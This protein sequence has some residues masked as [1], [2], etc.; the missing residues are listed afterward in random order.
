MFPLFFR[1]HLWPAVVCALFI[2][3]MDSPAALVHRWNFN[4]GSGTNVFDSIG[5]AHGWIVV[6][7]TVDYSRTPTN[8]HL[9][10]GTWSTA[11]FMQLPS[12]LVSSL[13]NVTIEVW[14][15]P[16]AVQNWSRIFDFGPGT[17]AGAANDYY[18]S[19]CRGTSLAQ[20]RME[21]DPAPAWRVDTGLATPVSNQYH[22]V[23]T[24]NKTGG[25]S[26]GG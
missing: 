3:G 16:R 15:T 9:G 20:Q 23:A 4:E 13:T 22:Y 11:D 21:H 26:G 1:N 14:A 5:S 19:F 25:P 6:S 7:N 18:L 10:G 8:V 12:G 17:G 24:W 2:A